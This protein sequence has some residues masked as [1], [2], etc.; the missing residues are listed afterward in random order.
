MW[1]GLDL[2]V[3]S[4]SPHLILIVAAWVERKRCARNSCLKP[5]IQASPS[6]LSKSFLSIQI[7]PNFNEFTFL[8]YWARVSKLIISSASMTPDVNPFYPVDTFEEFRVL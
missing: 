2:D 8:R 4:Q 1:F 3:E 7:P 5:P 6:L